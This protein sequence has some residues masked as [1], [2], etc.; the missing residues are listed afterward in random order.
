MHLGY[1]EMCNRPLRGAALIEA[2]WQGS[3]F[4]PFD[5]YAEHYMGFSTSRQPGPAQIEMGVPAIT[6][7]LLNRPVESYPLWVSHDCCASHCQ[8]LATA[9]GVLGGEIEDLRSDE[10]R[11]LGDEP[12][13]QTKG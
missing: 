11:R 10:T 6:R 1:L 2:L 8:M 12:L 5:H 9:F 3:R 13:P 7:A 4:A